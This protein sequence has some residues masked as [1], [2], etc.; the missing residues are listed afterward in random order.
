V[1][2]DPRKRQKKLERRKAKQ[3]AEKR[4]LARRESGGMPVQMERAAKA[5]VLHCFAAED[6][7]AHGIGNVLLSRQLSHGHVAFVAFLVDIYCLGVKDLIMN[8]APRA[9]YDEGLYDKLRRQTRLLPMK[10]EC[11]RKLV[12]G[13]V[14]YAL[15]LG[16]PPHPDYRIARL[17]FGDIP[18][19]ACDETFIYGKDGKPFYMAGPY[20]SPARVRQ[21][22]NA[23]E[24]ARGPGGYH[25]L[26]PVQGPGGQDL[27]E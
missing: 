22:L 8:V 27:V 5:P 15:D 17:I 13:A 24:K 10:P 3:K 6:V 25:F 11:A 14:E 1:P 16:L 12:E 23:L 4:A 9:R 2:V 7:W 19:D 20:D 26:A 18:A 21:I